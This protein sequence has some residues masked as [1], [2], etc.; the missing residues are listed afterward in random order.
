MSRCVYGFDFRAFLPE[1]K[2]IL[3]IN[4]FVFKNGIF[5][6]VFMADDLGPGLRRNLLAAG[7]I[8]GLQM[9]FKRFDDPGALRFGKV[10][11]K[12]NVS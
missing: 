5:K 11:V 8:I 10:L 3:I 9:G 2:N 1:L 6:I 4:T 12:L 7:N